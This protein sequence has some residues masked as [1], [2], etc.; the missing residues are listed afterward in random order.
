VTSITTLR[1]TI[2]WGKPGPGRYT[3][4]EY[5]Q[6]F[7]RRKGRDYKIGGPREPD[8]FQK[9]Y[10]PKWL[11]DHSYYYSGPVVPEHLDVD[12]GFGQGDMLR[13]SDGTIVLH[14]IGST[15]AVVLRPVLNNAGLYILYSEDGLRDRMPWQID[16]ADVP[17]PVRDAPD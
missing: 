16:R 7:Q 9:R 11:A 15:K 10:T 3:P 13:H 14:L 12:N 8:A 6:W 2:A 5:E 17:D 4:R 1:A